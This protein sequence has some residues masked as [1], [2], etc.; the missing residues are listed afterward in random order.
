MTVPLFTINFR[1]E[2]F[3]RRQARARARMVLLGVWVA[4]FGVMAVILGLYGLNAVTYARRAAMLE[5]QAKRIRDQ[6]DATEWTLTPEVLGALS[7]RVGS[8]S[9]HRDILVRLGQRLP[10]NVRLSSLTWNADAGSGAGA[11]RLVLGGTLRPEASQDRMGEVVRLVSMLSADSTLSGRFRNVKLASTSVDEG[12]GV[13]EFVIE[14][15]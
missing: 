3:R 5:R 2:V 8:L 1:R 6:R 10:T 9:T 14:C 12:S 7:E 11:R 4:Y 15:Q 13:V